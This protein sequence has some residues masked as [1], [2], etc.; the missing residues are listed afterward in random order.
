MADKISQRRVRGAKLGMTIQPKKKTPFD[1]LG[2]Q[3]EAGTPEE[4]RLEARGRRFAGREA[5]K[6]QKRIPKAKPDFRKRG[7]RA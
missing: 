6:T 4:E 5:A 3:M 2:K 7:V 1:E